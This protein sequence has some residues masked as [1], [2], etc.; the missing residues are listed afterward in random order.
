MNKPDEYEILERA[1]EAAGAHMMQ[2]SPRSDELIA[3]L[4]SEVKSRDARIAELELEVHAHLSRCIAAFEQ[5][6]QLRAD[7][8]AMKAQCVETYRKVLAASPSPGDSQ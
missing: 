7:L 4:E 2:K 6:D 8:A 1:H 3:C 5:N